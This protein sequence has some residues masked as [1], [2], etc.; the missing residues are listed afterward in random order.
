MYEAVADRQAG[1]QTAW[2]LHFAQNSFLAQRKSLKIF[3]FKR[4]GKDIGQKIALSMRRP[5]SS[6]PLTL[7]C[8]CKMNKIWPL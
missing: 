6:L 7:R 2:P 8:E 4:S 5:G 1:R 3:N